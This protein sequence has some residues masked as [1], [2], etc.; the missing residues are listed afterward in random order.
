M[1][2][3]ALTAVLDPVI[4][5]QCSTGESLRTRAVD[6]NTGINNRLGGIGDR[7][8]GV[9]EKTTRALFKVQAI[10][11]PISHL[12]IDNRDICQCWL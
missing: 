11:C 10:G 2:P 6:I 8:Y 7:H 1:H 9:V 5:N 12:V 4:N 3:L